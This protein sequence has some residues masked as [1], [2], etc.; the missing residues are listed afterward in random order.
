MPNLLVNRLYLNLRMMN[1]PPTP[2]NSKNNN[3]REPEAVRNRVLGNIGAPLDPDWW[4]TQFDEDEELNDDGLGEEADRMGTHAGDGTT[5]LVPVVS[6]PSPIS[7]FK[8]LK[9]MMMTGL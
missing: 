5:T 2:T 7:L 9:D 3:L 4:N 1:V 8:S 6:R